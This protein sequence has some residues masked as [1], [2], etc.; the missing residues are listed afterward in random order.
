MMSKIQIGIKRIMANPKFRQALIEGP[1]SL[2][3]GERIDSSAEWF[4]GVEYIHDVLAG[5]KDRVNLLL[6]AVLPNSDR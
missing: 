6:G 1:T 4:P 5:L 2:P 3:Q